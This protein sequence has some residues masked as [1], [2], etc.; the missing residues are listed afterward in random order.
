MKLWKAKAKVEVEVVIAAEGVPSEDAIL[1]A[2]GSE[3]EAG[4]VAL[5]LS[6]GPEPIQG[7]EDL[8]EPWRDLIP[9]GDQCVPRTTCAMILGDRS[10]NR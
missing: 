4:E 6:D 1:E 2:V 7:I 8:P 9:Y 5:V 10:E 3:M